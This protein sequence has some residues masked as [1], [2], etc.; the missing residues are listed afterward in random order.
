MTDRTTNKIMIFS[1]TTEGRTLSERL[2]GSGIPHT[3]CVATEYGELMM[4]EH[5]LVTVHTGRL[6]AEAMEKFI[7]GADIVCDATHPYAA[8][9]TE[10]IRRVCFRCG[11]RYIRVLRE[12]S[13]YDFPEDRLHVS[14]SSAECAA[15]LAGTDGNILLTTGSKEIGTYA[16]EESLKDRLFVRVLPSEESIGLCREAG[17]SSDHIIAMHGPFSEGLNAAIIEQYSIRHM[18]TKESGSAGGYSE[19][20]RAADRAGIDAWVIRRPSEESGVSVDQ[21]SEHIL[22]AV[23]GAAKEPEHITEKRV[24]HCSLI[25]IGP[26][27]QDLLTTA[28]REAIDGADAVF[29]AARMLETAA[30]RRKYPYYRAEDII[31][32]I[33]KEMPGR[34]AVLFSGDTGYYSGSAR[35][36]EKITAWADEQIHPGISSFSY[37]A[38]KTA[39]D[40]T[41]ATLC[42]LHGRSDDPEAT[43]DILRAVRTGRNVFVLLSGDRDV[44]LL[45]TLLTDAGLPDTEVIIGRDL[46]Y[47]DEAVLAITP[48]ECMSYE[49]QGLHIALVRN[50]SPCSRPLIPVMK[51]EDFIRDRVPMTKEQ[52][53]HASIIRLGLSKGSV[54]YDIGSGSGSVSVEAA[55]LDESV[56]VYAI[57][58][59]PEAMELT[60]ANAGKFGRTNIRFVSGSAPEA[61]RDLPPAT[62]AFIGGSG[63][64][65]KEIIDVLR[66]KNPEMRVVINAVSLETMAEIQ[67]IA[68][69]ENITDLTIEQISVSTSREAGR[70]HL[71][72]AENPVMIASFI[73]K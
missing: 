53:R 57:E 56:T 45:G 35:F 26:G 49:G 32:V 9:V 1:G 13:A 59:K 6:D 51:D 8:V 73:L 3:V 63:G 10:N 55:G 66:E 39:A 71:M 28:A 14:G 52:I 40:Y 42:S 18:V 54:L 29:G 50:P 27:R 23:S 5:P 68:G 21:A 31:P 22:N 65:L 7:D 62:H 2:A 43:A 69:S 70:Y 12:S 48:E 25:G 67:S 38:A 64:D 17:I 58:K 61:L 41:N 16:R 24:L 44:R 47:P 30:G 60:R 4:S 37:M 34:F 15:E 33:E 36:L 11:A 72:T 19:K 20:M 46:S